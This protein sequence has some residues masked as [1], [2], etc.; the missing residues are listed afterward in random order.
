[1]GIWGF[2][3]TLF[4]LLEECFRAFL[5]RSESDRPL[6][7]Y[8]SDTLSG[9]VASGD[10]RIRAVASDTPGFGVTFPSDRSE[11]GARI[12]ALIAEGRYPAD[13]RSAFRA[14]AT[15]NRP[16]RTDP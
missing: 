8:L 13:L 7:F 5:S 12:E 14:L 15:T 9:L 2:R 3:P 1:M 11:V 10:A 16:S 6:E 4:P